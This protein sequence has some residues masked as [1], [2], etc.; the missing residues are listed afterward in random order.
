MTHQK[1]CMITQRISNGKR[2]STLNM[3]FS[4]ATIQNEDTIETKSFQSLEKKLPNVIS[5]KNSW[6]MN[7]RKSTGDKKFTVKKAN[8]RI[9]CNRSWCQE[10][11]AK[12]AQVMSK[13]WLTLKRPSAPLPL[14][15][16]Y[17]TIG[18][19]MIGLSG[20]D[21]FGGSCFKNSWL[22][23]R[24]LAPGISLACFWISCLTNFANDSWFSAINL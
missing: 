12:L 3:A 20:S 13:G 7:Q 8:T 21:C 16:D 19:G 10:S 14:P 4:L 17:L 5:P 9:G 22:F 11:W 2:T 6:S 1:N 23:K 24:R 15:L 18:R